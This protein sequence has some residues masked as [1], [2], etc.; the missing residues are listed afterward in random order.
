METPRDRYW[1]EWWAERN[2]E[3]ATIQ[4]LFE[5]IV[6]ECEDVLGE[7]FEMRTAPH[8]ENRDKTLDADES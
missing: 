8:R 7:K 2:R 5:S 4:S 3:E 6:A 1:R